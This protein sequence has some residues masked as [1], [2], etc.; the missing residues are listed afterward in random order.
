MIFSSE[1]RVETIMCSKFCCGYNLRTGGSVVGYLSI[2]FYISLFLLSII[3]LSRL[4]NRIDELEKITTFR[5]KT[6]RKNYE[7]FLEDLKGENKVVNQELESDHLLSFSLQS[8]ETKKNLMK[9]K[10]ELIKF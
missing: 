1:F 8:V 2:I 3:Y 9:L 6:S 4:Q 10:F 7:T 5:S